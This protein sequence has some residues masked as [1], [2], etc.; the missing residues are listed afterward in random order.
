LTE[1]TDV[2]SDNFFE[3]TAGRQTHLS[4]TDWL[5][6]HYGCYQNRWTSRSQSCYL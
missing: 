1:T 6:I 4:S 5:F 3:T 2:Q